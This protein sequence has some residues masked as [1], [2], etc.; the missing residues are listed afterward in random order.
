MGVFLLYIDKQMKSFD[1]S[2]NC[3]DKVYYN[4]VKGGEKYVAEKERSIIEAT[5]VRDNQTKVIEISR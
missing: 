4:L 5:D 2:Q 3:F 1:K